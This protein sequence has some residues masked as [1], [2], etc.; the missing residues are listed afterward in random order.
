MR[1]AASGMLSVLL[2]MQAHAQ[3]TTD[4]DPSRIPLAALQDDPQDEQAKTP[5]DTRSSTLFLEGKAESI[6]RRPL[7]VPIPATAMNREVLR[8]LIDGR[9][10]WQLS[11]HLTAK[12]SAQAATVRTHDGTYSRDE[13]VNLREAALQ[14]RI[15]E[16]D[17][18][19]AGRVNLRQGAALGFNPTDFF[20]TRTTVDTTTRD[21]QV[22]RVNR[23]GTVMLNAQ[24]FGKRSSLLV[25]IAPRLAQA[26]RYSQPE[27]QERLRL[28]D[29]N[30]EDRLLVKGQL[31]LAPDVSPELLAFKDPNGWRWG[32]NLTQAQGQQS[33]W[34]VEYA[35]GRS[36][37]L[38]QRALQSGVALG[39]LPPSALAA[40]RPEA[41]E[42]WQSD[43]A[44]G[45]TWTGENRLS[46]TAEFDYHQAGFNDADWQRWQALGALGGTGSQLAWY[47]RGYGNAQQEPLYRRNLFLRAQWEQ[48]GHRDLSVNAFVNRN[49]D[50]RSS[51]F[52]VALEYRLN[53]SNRLRAM[54]L[55]TTGRANSLYGSDPARHAVLLSY[56]HYLES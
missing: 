37:S 33:T 31:T 39:D 25:A 26:G 32:V 18:L 22:Q 34:F 43:L 48:A 12:A 5:R 44:I 49:L 8:L 42:Q 46:L 4:D 52:Q 23:L 51:L 13:E 36:H 3:T 27:P 10:D 2:A 30:G 45:W 35:G 24:R 41:R 11:P 20:K 40:S 6:Q 54:A 14:W 17:V 28:S 56:V 50:D 53:Q 55:F 29:T 1:F 9:G 47:L 15:D 19:E 38:W 21:P 16:Q 7:L